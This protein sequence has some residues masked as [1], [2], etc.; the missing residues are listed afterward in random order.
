MRTP[1]V[2]VCGQG[3]ADGV[4]D[5]LAQESGTAV[6]RHRF[7]GHV[8][9]EIANGCVACTVRN[10]LLVL[11]RRL[12]RRSDIRRIAVRLMPWLE[13]EPVCWAIENVRVRVGPGYIDGPAARDVYI[14]AS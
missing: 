14:D 3:N 5:V 11:L 4:A 2:L 10:D 7:D 8:V 13:P 6:V 1:V 12:H 9:V